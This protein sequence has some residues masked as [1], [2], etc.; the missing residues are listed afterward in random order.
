MSIET[1]Y[2]LL[3]NETAIALVKKFKFLDKNAQLHCTE[4]GDGNLNYVFH[5]T[6][7]DSGKGII[8]KQAVP[9]AK[10]VGESWP[11]TLK[12]ASMEAQALINFGSYCPEYVPKVYYSDERLAI[13]VM[14]DL[15]H[16]TIA[17]AG[18][19]EGQDYPLIS[20]H[21]GEYAART[22]FYTS[23]FY[24]DPSVKKEVSRTF[25]NPELCKITESYVFTDPFFS[26][27]PTDVENGLEEAAQ[28]IWNDENL[29][30]EVAILKKQFSSEQEALLHGDLHT[31]SVFASETESKVIDPEFV[32]YGPV[33]FDLGLFIGNLTF[34]AISRKNGKEKIYKHI[35]TFWSAFEK[36]YS[37]L[38]QTENNEEF[39]TAAGYL[40]YILKKFKEDAFGYAGCE[41][42]RRTIGLSHV[43]DLEEIEDQ[44]ERIA[45]KENALT[46]GSLLIK[47][48]KQLDFKTFI[49]ELQ[50][51]AEEKNSVRV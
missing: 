25:T 37:D 14:E 40:D 39:R 18:F 50:D 4:I 17:R 9:Y 6:D 46:I 36:T 1:S 19:I 43:A 2:E 15:S 35:Q 3:T 32:C 12:R 16:L 47:K 8:I 11:L 13:T 45:A 28:A 21:V 38:W 44:K 10:V 23:D 33:G 7:P 41:L 27:T 42:I 24:L 49:T 22:S 5:I 29:K 48:R 34:Q 31:G 30:L 26:H 20:R 51:L